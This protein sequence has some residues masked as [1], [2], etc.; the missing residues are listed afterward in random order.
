MQ[1]LQEFAHDPDV[2]AFYQAARETELVAKSL[3]ALKSNLKKIV[4]KVVSESRLFNGGTAC[5][6]D[7]VFL[8]GTPT[9]PEDW[10]RIAPD[11]VLEYPADHRPSE[12][13]A[14]QLWFGAM[15]VGLVTSRACHVT[16]FSYCRIKPRSGPCFEK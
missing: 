15:V 11:L 5:S 3:S 14:M 13:S 10:L 4:R 8:H 6:V 12:V 2:Q 1:F 9:T 16:D 7:G